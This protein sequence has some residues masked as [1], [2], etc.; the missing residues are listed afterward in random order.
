M[1]LILRKTRV[2]ARIEGL[3]PSFW[4]GDDYSIIDGETRVGRVYRERIQGEW[5]WLWFLQT[6]PADTKQRND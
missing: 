1:K 2:Q 3:N 4:G 6:E 5:R